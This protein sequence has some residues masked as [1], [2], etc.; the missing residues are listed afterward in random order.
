M[1]KVK[2]TKGEIFLYCNGICQADLAK[3]IGLSKQR[4][5]QIIKTGSKSPFIIHNIAKALGISRDEVD[6][7]LKPN[8]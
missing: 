3:E 1:K 6:E 4:V 7:L 5:N 2:R 8:S